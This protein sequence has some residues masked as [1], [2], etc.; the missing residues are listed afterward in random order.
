MAKLPAHA[1][2][3]GLDGNHAVCDLMDGSSEQR[4]RSTGLEADPHVQ[5]RRVEGLA[6]GA[7][8]RPEDVDD[9][10]PLRAPSHEDRRLRARRKESRA[11]AGPVGPR[12]PDV[13]HVFSQS[14]GHL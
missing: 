13:G 3:E 4:A 10:F 8:Q 2:P 12:E 14:G 7:G 1:A 6:L 9:G 5:P 11:A